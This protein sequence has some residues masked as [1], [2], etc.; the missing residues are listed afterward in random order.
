MSNLW[1]DKERSYLLAPLDFGKISKTLRQD[2]LTTYSVRGKLEWQIL[3]F[4]INGGI[5]LTIRILEPVFS[6]TD[7]L[8][9]SNTCLSA[10]P[11]INKETS[12]FFVKLS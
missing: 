1:N 2:I 6:Q 4:N 7:F 11:S 5:L 3:D 12:H 8:I 10:T 9:F